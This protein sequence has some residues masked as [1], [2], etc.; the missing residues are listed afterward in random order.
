[1]EDHN[2]NKQHHAPQK[3]GGQR[4]S[5]RPGGFNPQ[6][7]AR[8]ATKQ[9]VQAAQSV[10]SEKPQRPAGNQPANKGA[11]QG[12]NQG[13]EAAHRSRN[14][15]RRG[16]GGEKPQGEKAAPSQEKPAKEEKPQPPAWEAVDPKPPVIRSG[17][18]E[19]HRAYKLT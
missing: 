12:G 10:A 3:D 16:R 17:H 14:R 7:E 5:V 15:R 4:I 6:G 2:K 1:M 19:T 8:S 11:N 9:T 13:G 18:M